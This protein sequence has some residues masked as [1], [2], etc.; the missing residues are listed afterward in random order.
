MWPGQPYFFRP[1]NWPA[2]S[3]AKH[4][5]SPAVWKAGCFGHSIWRANHEW[6][7]TRNRRSVEISGPC[8][9]LSWNESADG[10]WPDDYSRIRTTDTTIGCFETR[11]PSAAR[12]FYFQF[13][14]AAWR[15]A[16]V[17]A[18]FRIARALDA[19][20]TAPHLVAEIPEGHRR[21]RLLARNVFHARRHR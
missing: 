11:R 2:T 17:L 4:W 18:G 19:L 21:Y 9:Y 16:G 10:S 15:D 7:Q 3:R 20:G 12:G 13:V 1:I 8:R 6:R 14:S 5:S